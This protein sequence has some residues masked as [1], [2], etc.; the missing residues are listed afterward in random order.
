MNSYSRRQDGRLA[1]RKP[2]RRKA[3]L[4]RWLAA[5]L[6]VAAGLAGGEAA[7][8]FEN[9]AINPA[10]ILVVVPGT[11][12]S[13]EAN[14]I[15]DPASAIAQAIATLRAPS[16]IASA[17]KQLA[18][19]NDAEFARINSESSLANALRITREADAPVI[20]ISADLPDQTLAVALSNNLSHILLD[21][22]SVEQPVK[23]LA[24]DDKAQAALSSFE[25][26]DG[27]TINPRREEIAGSEAAI[28]D[29]D[30]SVAA[31]RKRL[32]EAGKVRVSDVLAGKFPPDLSTPRLES[33]L[34][35]YASEK[36]DYEGLALKLGP[37]HP[38]LKAA[39]TELEATKASITSE[40]SSIT[41]AARQTLQTLVAK[42]ATLNG[43][44]TAQK[45]ELASLEDRR[46]YLK[47]QLKPMP[48]AD[49]LTNG[50][51]A[52]AQ[53]ALAPQVRYRLVSPATIAVP[54]VEGA[55]INHVAGGLLGLLVGAIILFGGRAPSASRH[56]VARAEPRMT[57]K[58][59]PRSI[60]DQISELEKMW[61]ETGRKNAMPLATNDEPVQQEMRHARQAVMAMN[62]LRAQ[63]QDAAK[64]ASS[65]VSSPASN[66]MSNRA[67]NAASEASLERVLADMQKLR[68]KVQWY[69]AEQE[70]QQRLS[71]GGRRG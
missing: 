60:L 32:D 38:Q 26:S 7:V 9:A 57:A 3:G 24:A 39:V 71:G 68:A 17:V 28:R 36:A 18:L 44:L 1:A 66:Q 52:N 65:P 50:K 48:V 29:L 64:H 23:T 37:L 69:A 61:P 49:D 31:T 42:Q 13:G 12:T 8:R 46:A 63:A 53:A 11:V 40:V 55:L 62:I 4:V 14:G 10:R 34:S 51:V 67:A 30:L 47:A 2:V 54:D 16:A 15:V 25:E 33:L 19:Q 43:A 22:P 56:V 59:A 6:A 5:S 21:A 35:S 70:R 58:P 27:A 45:A 41:L 20:S